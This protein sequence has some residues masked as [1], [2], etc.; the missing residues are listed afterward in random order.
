MVGTISPHWIGMSPAVVVEKT[1][2][3][4]RGEFRKDIS[5]KKLEGAGGEF[6]NVHLKEMK[7]SIK[8]CPGRLGLL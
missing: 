7:F 6:V 5:I 4:L 3:N 8:F 2:N 1:K